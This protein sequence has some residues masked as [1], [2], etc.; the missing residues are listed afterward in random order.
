M[1]T[2]SL[3]PAART[4]AFIVENEAA[5]FPDRTAEEKA[6]AAQVAAMLHA[7]PDIRVTHGFPTPVRLRRG[8]KIFAMRV[9][10]GA[11][12][13]CRIESDGVIS[14]VRVVSV[15]GEIF[16]LLE[17]GRRR[18][19][20]LSRLSGKVWARI[21]GRNWDFE[22]ISFEPTLRAEAEGD[23]RV[24]ATM[25]GRVVSVDVA[26]GERVSRGQKLLVLE[27]MKMEHVH[28]AYIDGTVEAIHVAEGEQVEARRVVV[29]VKA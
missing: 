25:N 13:A 10:A 7:A 8:E 9:F 29:E 21:D 20:V 19:A 1:S 18:R 27:A 16:E 22:D 3:R 24:R 14:E 28:V 11:Y 12:G 17:G 6:A 4:T 26:V 15:Q 5:L 2:L 23:G